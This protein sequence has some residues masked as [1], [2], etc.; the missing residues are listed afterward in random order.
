MTSE[1]PAYTAVRTIVR[2]AVYMA[3]LAIVVITP[4]WIAYTLFPV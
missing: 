2:M 4:H 3:L 1:R